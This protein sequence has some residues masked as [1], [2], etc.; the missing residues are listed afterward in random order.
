MG[1]P[2]VPVGLDQGLVQHL[3]LLV[4]HVRDEQAE[5]GHELLDFPGQQG[6]HLP[7]GDF[8]DEL[9]LRGGH[10]ADLHDI[11][12][13]RGTWGDFDE[14]PAYVDAGPAKLMAL[15][16][17]HNKGLYPPHPHPKG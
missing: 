2:E 17:R 10:M 1:D 9:H 15:D 3:L 6:I 12:A 7:I 14:L 8:V 5:E 16:G 11:D 4:G 13:V